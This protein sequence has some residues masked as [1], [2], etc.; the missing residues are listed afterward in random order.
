MDEIVEKANN[1][2]SRFEI[3]GKIANLNEYWQKKST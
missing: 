3:P 2:L 1:N